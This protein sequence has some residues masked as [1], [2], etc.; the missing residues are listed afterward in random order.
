MGERT[1]K[2]NRARAGG[3]LWLLGF[4]AMASVGLILASC[5]TSPTPK[6]EEKV[7]PLPP[8][9]PRIRYLE[10][11]GDEKISALWGEAITSWVDKLMGE[12]KGWGQKLRKPY[13]VAVDSQG[14]VY[15]ADPG[16]AAVWVI[17]E[18]E[19]EKKARVRTVGSSGSVT[20]SQ[21]TG[22]AVAQD[23]RIYVSDVSRHQVVGFDPQGEPKVMFG[24]SGD[25]FKP[26]GLAID[27]KGKRLYVADSGHHCIQVFDLEGKRLFV[28]GYRGRDPGL[29]NYPTNLFIRG[30]RLYVTDTMNFRIQI[31][32]LEGKPIYTFGEIGDGM[33]Q[34]SRP[35]GIA[36]DSE[37]HIYVA[38]AG[39]DNFQI[40][41]EKGRLLL[42]VGHAGYDVGEFT[43]PAGMFIDEEDRVYVVDS[44][45][46]RVQVF[47]YLSGRYKERMERETTGKK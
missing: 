40:F 32:T 26:A 30:D 1:E 38:D 24:Q 8:E 46:R 22:V 5:A 47:Q 10:S 31:L 4:W 11:I 42:F 39:F 44:Y 9:L 45:N 23:G 34:F 18:R 14:R 35:K 36:V 21:P 37:G 41:D 15:V 25:F 28:I 13:G 19:K 29:F 3:R 20:L 12:T 16:M 43:L 7:W 27:Q 6:K 17:D 33:G 2:R